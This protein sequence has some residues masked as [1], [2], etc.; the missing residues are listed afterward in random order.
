LFVDASGRIGIAGSPSA[1]SNTYLQVG[2]AGIGSDHVAYNYDSYFANNLYK[3]ANSAWSR[4]STR[5][6]GLLRIDDD[7]FTY[8]TADSGTA[9]ASA[10]LSERLRITSAGLV[11]IGTSAPSAR[12]HS[13]ETSAAE[14]LRVDG[15]DFGFSFIVEGG[16][17]RATKIRHA[18]IGNSYVGSTPPTDGLLVQGSVGIGTTS[19][20]SPLEVAGSIRA[21]N[22]SIFATNGTTRYAL[23]GYDTD[24]ALLGTAGL[25]IPLIFKTGNG[26][27]DVERARIDSSGTEVHSALMGLL[28]SAEVLQALKAQCQK[29]G[30]SRLL[31]LPL[32]RKQFLLTLF[33]DCHL[34]L[35]R[36]W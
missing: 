11:G 7:T 6:G 28:L 4:I 10:T 14:G 32:Q 17:T 23:L 9:G 35:L 16:T 31:L 19:P 5:A 18:T 21:T 15:A 33:K 30:W 12:L 26:S 34:L 27:T 36:T 29:L 20:G 3:S 13:V 22:G 8:S 1:S 25:N 24:G 2:Y